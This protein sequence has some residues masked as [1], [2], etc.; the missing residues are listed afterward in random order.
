[1]QIFL[2]KPRMMRCRAGQ[3][4]SARGLREVEQLRDEVGK[5]LDRTRRQ[6]GKEDGEDGEVKGVADRRVTLDA[7]LVQVV[8]ELE[9]EEGNAERDGRVPPHGQ[10]RGQRQVRCGEPAGEGA[11]QK[12]PVFVKDQRADQRH[13]HAVKEPAA[14]PVGGRDGGKEGE[15]AE[16]DDRSHAG[17]SGEMVVEDGTRGEHPVELEPAR[18]EPVERNGG[19]GEDPEPELEKEHGS[20]SARAFAGGSRRSHGW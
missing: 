4:S 18:A 16:P 8:D 1:M 2:N 5:A 6:G 15:D 11:E 3:T 7:H 13:P 10:C 9:G 17:R 20:A 19:G 12:L 14:A